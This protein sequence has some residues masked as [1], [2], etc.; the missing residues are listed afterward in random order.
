MNIAIDR[1]AQHQWHNPENVPAD[2]VPSGWR[3]LTVVEARTL[4]SDEGLRWLPN[5]RIYEFDPPITSEDADDYLRDNWTYLIRDDQPI[6][7]R[8]LNITG[9]ASQEQQDVEEA[10]RRYQSSPITD[11]AVESYA[12]QQAFLAGLRHARSQGK[13]EV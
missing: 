8:S 1:A 11:E 6:S 13:E 5:G 10:E 12:L 7:A 3:F 9:G 4:N 2:K